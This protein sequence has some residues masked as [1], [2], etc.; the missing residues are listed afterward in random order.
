MSKGDKKEKLKLAICEKLQKKC[1][2]IYIQMFMTKF[3]DFQS[4]VCKLVNSSSLANS[5]EALNKAESM[6]LM[7]LLFEFVNK[8]TP[9]DEKCQKLSEMT[10]MNHEV[11]RNIL[12]YIK[13]DEDTKDIFWFYTMIL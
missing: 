13:N 8:I 5:G 6:E 11:V 7:Q 9:L 2:L 1:P 4:E 10:D 12:E 3:C